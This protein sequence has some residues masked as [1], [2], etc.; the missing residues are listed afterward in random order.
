MYSCVSGLALLE[1]D[2]LVLRQ[3]LQTL[4]QLQMSH[5]DTS[6]MQT[7][8][9]STTR[10]ANQYFMIYLMLHLIAIETE[11]REVQQRASELQKK[12]KRLTEQVEARLKGRPAPWPQAEAGVTQGELRTS[13]QTNMAALEAVCTSIKQTEEKL[14]SETED[15][16]KLRQTEDKL[17][18]GTTKVKSSLLTNPNS[19]P[20]DDSETEQKYLELVDLLTV[21]MFESSTAAEHNKQEK[22]QPNSKQTKKSNSL[23][24]TFDVQTTAPK[25]LQK[26]SSQNFD[27]ENNSGGISAYERLF[28]RPRPGIVITCWIIS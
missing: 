16:L 28:G 11:L 26:S 25:T 3:E 4:A 2:L 23:P 7:L 1:H 20:S 5:G 24:R 12:A 9:G 8:G 21:K 18:P 6:S 15:K 10:H 19:S 27:V 22:N 14:R 17:R 13:I